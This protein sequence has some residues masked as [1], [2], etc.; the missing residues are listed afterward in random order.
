MWVPPKDRAR[1]VVRQPRRPAEKGHYATHRDGRFTVV[2][3]VRG[4]AFARVAR[5]AY[6]PVRLPAGRLQRDR[7]LRT[8]AVTFPNGC[9]VCEVEIDEATGAVCVV[10]LNAVDDVGRM[11][12]P[13]LVKGQ[14]HGGSRPGAGPGALRPGRLH[15]MN[16]LRMRQC[17]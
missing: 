8:A 3:T 12:N 9:Q 16:H 17:Q 7:G 14:I 10:R 1:L 11:V 2:G 6:A 5:A 4:L 15:R 13:L